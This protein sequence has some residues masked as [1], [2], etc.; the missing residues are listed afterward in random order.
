MSHTT[1]FKHDMV[2]RKTLKR[3][4]KAVK[5]QNIGDVR[6]QVEALDGEV[7]RIAKLLARFGF[8][9][10]PTRLELAHVDARGMGGNPDLSRDTVENTLLVSWDLHNGGRYSIHGECI[11]I[12]LLTERGTRGPVA[13]TFYE[14][15]PKAANGFGSEKRSGG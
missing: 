15:S 4:R 3:R 9:R 12:Q 10:V 6:E 7:C 2:T 5:T 1:N 14:Q 8:M 13:V 11:A